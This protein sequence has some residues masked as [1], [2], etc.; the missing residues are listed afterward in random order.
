MP[1]GLFVSGLAASAPAGQGGVTIGRMSDAYWYC[2]TCGMVRESETAPWCRHNDPE[3]A[4]AA[5]RMVPLPAWS[6]L[7]P[8]ELATLPKT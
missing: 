2:R 4:I 5:A 8:A 1:G 3:R 7:T 6:P